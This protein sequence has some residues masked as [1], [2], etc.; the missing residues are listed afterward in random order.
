M[1]HPDPET[2]IGRLIKLAGERDM[3]TP[4]GTERARLAAHESWSRMLLERAPAPRRRGAKAMLG[5][6]MAAGVAALALLSWNQ[7]STPQV[8]QVVARIATLTGGASLRQDRGESIASVS[9]PIYSGSTLATSEGRVALTFG[10]SLSLRIDRQTRLRF[11]GRNQVTLLEGALY[12]DSGGVNTVP[13]LR[14]ETPAGVVRHVGTQFQV[15]VTGGTTRVR[16]REGR[17]LLERAS[18]APTD[19]AAG[20]ELR[21]AGDDLRW[22]RGLPSFGADWEWSAAIAPALEIENRPLAEFLTWIAREH[23][24]QVQYTDETLQHR[25][26]DIRLHGSL[27]QLDSAAMLE[28]VALVTGVSLAAREGVLWVGGGGR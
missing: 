21:I 1:T 3:P 13:A 7:R 16:V 10:D 22:Q 4:E 26:L 15:Q 17:V 23:G 24:W 5:F 6:A 8:P 14:I 12:V 25:T 19:I 18:G 20:D 28:R 27:D 9:A 11:D 2:S